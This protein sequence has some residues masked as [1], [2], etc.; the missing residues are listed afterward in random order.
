VEEGCRKTDLLSLGSD[1]IDLINE[2]DS[3]RVLLGLLERLPQVRLGLSRHLGHD[4]RTVDEEEERSGLVSNGSGHEGLSGSGRS[5]HED[6]S[7]RL[8]TDRLEELGVSQGELDELSD[9]SH[10]HGTR[11]DRISSLLLLGQPHDR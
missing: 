9:L 2:D 8:D 5:E 11:S 3:G 10:L 4:L 6:T 7:G 1:R